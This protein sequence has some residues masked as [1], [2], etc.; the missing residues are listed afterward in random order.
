MSVPRDSHDATT[1]YIRLNA[2]QDDAPSG[3]LGST[4]VA[5]CLNSVGGFLSS[6]SLILM[7]LAHVRAERKAMEMKREGGNNDEDKKQPIFCTCLWMSSFVLL[8]VGSLANI[9]GL[10]FG[11]QLLLSALASLSI[12][13]NTGLSVCILKETWFKSDFLAVFLMVLGAVL[14]LT[15]AHN[16]KQD[17]T[18]EELKDLYLRT[19]SLAVYGSVVVLVVI[20]YLIDIAM[21]KKLVG[22]MERL[23]ELAMIDAE[24][25]FKSPISL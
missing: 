23:K 11:N 18:F 3:G 15:C 20:A 10:R 9:V 8:I 24:G 22:Y 13:F 4:I 21:R 16:S 7:K 19:E 25:L 2:L 5:I 1:F 17:Y 14:F 6:L 12:I